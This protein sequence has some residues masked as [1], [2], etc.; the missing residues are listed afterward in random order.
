MAKQGEKNM[1]SSSIIHVG[2]LKGVSTYTCV[3][4]LQIYT[5]CMKFDMWIHLYKDS[6][7]SNHFEPQSG[8]Q[9]RSQAILNG[10]VVVN[11]Y[12]LTLL[13]MFQVMPFVQAR[14]RLQFTSYVADR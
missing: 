8:F 10:M 9:K 7:G 12:S 2:R 3:R 1:P 14:F 4:I 13:L 11:R 6:L 5:V